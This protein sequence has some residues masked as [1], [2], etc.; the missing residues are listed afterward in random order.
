[1]LIGVKSELQL[2]KALAHVRSVG[3]A[4]FPFHEAD[5]D[6]QMTAFAT[7]IVGGDERRLFRKYQLFKGASCVAR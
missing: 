4:C 2:E 1:V 7:R 3:V 6:G 5:L